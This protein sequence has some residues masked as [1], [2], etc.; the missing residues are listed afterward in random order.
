MFDNIL[1]LII[2]IIIIFLILQSFECM[3]DFNFDYFNSKFSKF[4]NV[5]VYSYDE[6]IEI[7]SLPITQQLNITYDYS[8]NYNFIVNNNVSIYQDMKDLLKNTIEI[9][10]INY[11]LTSIRWKVSK[12]TLENKQVGLD[13]WLV[14][15]NFNSLHKII[16]I[17]PL[18]LVSYKESFKNIN[19]TQMTENYSLYNNQVVADF[20]DP[21]FNTPQYFLKNRV[22]DLTIASQ[23][24]S[25]NLNL[26]YNSKLLNNLIKVDAIS[27]YECCK[28]TI[29]KPQ[30]IIL[31][32]IQE[33]LNTNTEYH[34]LKDRD[35]N[36]YYIS[37][38]FEFREDIGLHILN[39]IEIDQSISFMKPLENV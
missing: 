38:P 5:D 34:K 24:N 22:T 1:L 17:I 3:T 27:D 4:T 18:S 28:D 15:Q 26:S 21:K 23:S 16:I 7:K 12:F 31:T 2:F 37:K 13:L 9:D 39:K 11:N 19:Y 32:G 36:T 20:S 10:N 25:F 14:H 35:N 8:D 6:Y 30:N 29:G 33:L